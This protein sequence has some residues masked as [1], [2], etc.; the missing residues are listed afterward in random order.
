[1]G[2]SLKEKLAIIKARAMYLRNREEAPELVDDLIESGVVGRGPDAVT[3]KP[4]RPAGRP[5]GG[6]SFEQYKSGEPGPIE[7]IE[8]GEE[9]DLDGDPFYLVLATGE[10][11]DPAAPDE[12]SM[13]ARLCEWPRF[14]E[15]RMYSK[16]P[17]PRTRPAGGWKP[18][19]FNG[20]SVCFL[21]IETTGLS[22]TTYL[23]LIGLM[24]F[25][26]GQFVMEQVFA[27]NYAEE[28]AVLKYVR[29]R[30]S[31]FESLVTYN[32]ASFDIPFIETRLAALRGQPLQPI[33]SVDLLYTARKLYRGVLPN[34]RL[35]TVEHHIRGIDRTGDIPGAQIPG[36]YHEYVRTGDARAMKNVLYHNRMDLFTMAMLINRL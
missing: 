17:S 8:P 26:D 6:D 18:P 12:Q 33:A 15:P 30:L 19:P 34:C 25:T 36:V 24:Y 14:V 13:W 20:E 1:M 23:F 31:R 28:A 21:D 9:R 5:P 32:G 27:R 16:L 2:K 10:S 22:P 3:D 35:G 4:A 7:K 29:K 11:V